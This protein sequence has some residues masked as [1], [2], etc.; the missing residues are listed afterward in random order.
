M[1]WINNLSENQFALLVLVVAAAVFF[2][3]YFIV[4]RIL[5]RHGRRAIPYLVAVGGAC[6]LGIVVCSIALAA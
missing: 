5:N 2:P 1:N 4:L 6:V 3:G